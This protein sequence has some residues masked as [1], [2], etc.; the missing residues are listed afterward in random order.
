MR[1]PIPHFVNKGDETMKESE[2]TSE[3]YIEA[4]LD[5]KEEKIGDYT[6]RAIKMKITKEDIK[7]AIKK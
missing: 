6:M 1:L 7:R 5:T 3:Q 4:H 2:L